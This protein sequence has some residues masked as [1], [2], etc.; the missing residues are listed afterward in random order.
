MVVTI[1]KLLNNLEKYFK[2]GLGR[3]LFK[4]AGILTGVVAGHHY[5][6]KVFEYSA[7]KREA[8]AQLQR[9]SKINKM[10]EDM[11]TLKAQ[12]AKNQAL[13]ENIHTQNTELKEQ[14]NVLITKNETLLAK[15]QE[16]NI[17]T[18]K[19]LISSNFDIT[20]VIE[21]I[22]NYLDTLTLLQESAVIHLIFSFLLIFNAFGMLA[23]FFGNELI[24]YL[25]LSKKYPKLTYF[26][27]VRNKFQR[28]F[29]LWDI[30]LMF[31]ICGFCIFIDLLTL[32]YV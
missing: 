22:H 21:D 17:D 20:S 6:S 28:F 9:D 26:L 27:E 16:S 29:L 3:G 23:I 24:K 30:L 31:S 2:P 14:N 15:Q 32:Y 5:F 10:V 11:E 1:L 7:N 4:Q 12:N 13:L 25:D 8:E 18:P 19:K